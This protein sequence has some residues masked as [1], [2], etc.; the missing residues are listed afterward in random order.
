MSRLGSVKFYE[1][2]N[3]RSP[4][5]LP[6]LS[7]ALTLI[8]AA[9]LIQPLVAVPAVA[10][11]DSFGVSTYTRGA[12]RIASGQYLSYQFNSSDVTGGLT[13]NASE[14]WSIAFHMN[15]TNSGNFSN[16]F[17]AVDEL[18]FPVFALG[19]GTGATVLATY[20][21]FANNTCSSTNKT[22][23][24][25]AGPMGSTNGASYPYRWEIN[26]DASQ[27]C[28]NRST[29]ASFGRDDQVSQDCYSKI[30]SNKKIKFGFF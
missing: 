18:G 24:T 14:T 2:T 4:G 20:T 12:I 26:Q 3:E 10:A 7:R 11:E 28:V 27:V 13:F 30:T 15:V 25:P 5:R 29:S 16:F 1:S 9:C 22:R 19:G 17:T 23:G 8:L 6:F 21:C